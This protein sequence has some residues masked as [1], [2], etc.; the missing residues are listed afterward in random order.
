MPI[1]KLKLITTGKH[2]GAR[3]DELIADW[4]TNTLKR[5]VSKAKARKLVMAGAVR[6][7][8]Q[9]VRSA[10]D[11]LVPGTSIEAWIDKSKLFRDATSRDK[12]FDVTDDRI[13]F[14]DEDLI[15]IDKP[16]GLPSQPTVDQAR[17]NL[18]AALSRFVGRRDGVEEPY[19][20]VHQRL[21]RDTS[22]VVLF[23]KSRRV[24]AA[25]SDIFSQRLGTKI[26]QAITAPPERTTP[27]DAW[28]IK[29]RLGK[30]SSKAKRTNYGAVRADGDFA[31]TSF[32]VLER[33]SRG[34]WIEASPKT[35]RT[36]QIR[37]HLA[38]HGLPILGDDLYGMHNGGAPRLMLHACELRFP[39]PI[40]RDE[41]VVRSSMPADFEQCLR[42]LRRP[43]RQS[44]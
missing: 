34:L 13:L 39:H 42:S 24:N 6:L 36:H 17:D 19:I 41:V 29:N 22:G 16:S 27:G 11:G 2:A 28:T 10:S 35:G 23:T 44:Q 8:G 31:E 37:V 25:V 5:E 21:D 1:T 38:E 4:L 12:A 26:Y 18:Y 32:R 33:H 43:E 9:R 20:G 40:T 30:V 14:E 7:D 15:A 3:L